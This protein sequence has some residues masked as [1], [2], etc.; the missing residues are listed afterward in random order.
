M[1]LNKSII[2]ILCLLLSAS[3][4]HTSERASIS[5][6][7]TVIPMLGI[8]TQITDTQ[9][10]SVINQADS[11]LCIQAPKNSTLLIHIAKANQ[12]DKEK[13]FL[14]SKSKNKSNSVADIL[15]IDLSKIQT[16]DKS[17]QTITILT[18][19]N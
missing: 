15:S 13:T 10:L 17:Q 8:M 6:T 1:K 4:V 3:V 9:S 7:A 18:I 5:A 16:T 14:L 2:L 19:D 11:K 12:S